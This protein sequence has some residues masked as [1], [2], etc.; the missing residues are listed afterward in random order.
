MHFVCVCVGEIISL[1]SFSKELKMTYRRTTS[2]VASSL[3]FSFANQYLLG[4][5]S[6]SG[7]A[8]VKVI[9]V[10]HSYQ[11]WFTWLSGNWCLCVWVAWP[12]SRGSHQHLYH[13]I[14]EILTM[15]NHITF[16][17]CDTCRN[18]CSS[19]LAITLPISSSH[20]H[21]IDLIHWCF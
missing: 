4:S 19:A 5:V 7:C 11:T 21:F 16:F 12:W 1:L 14:V 17:F 20:R 2:F 8:L 15:I 10:S 6:N 18:S 3:Y 9:F 13:F